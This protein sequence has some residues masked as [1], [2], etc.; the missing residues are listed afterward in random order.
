M[1]RHGSL[2][3]FKPNTKKDVIAAALAKLAPLLDDSSVI[4]DDVPPY[5]I[6]EYDDEWGC[7][8]TFYIP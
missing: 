2:L 8:P 4:G 5:R 7:E 3:I 1:K 6:E